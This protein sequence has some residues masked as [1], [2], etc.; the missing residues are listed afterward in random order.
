MSELSSLAMF[1]PV[2]GAASPPLGG[3]LRVRCEDFIVH[4]LPM[5]E[6]DD[7]GEHLYL[8]LRKQDCPHDELINLIA[9]AHGVHRRAVG[10]AGMKDA[11]AVTEQTL[12]CLLYTSPSPRDV[13]ESRMPSSA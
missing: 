10:F 8:R 7:A 4:E 3:V 9:R 6:P 5:Y 2:P 12:S 13:E 1:P 11:R